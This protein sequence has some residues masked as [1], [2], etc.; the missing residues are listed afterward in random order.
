[1]GVRDV[2]IRNDKDEQLAKYS[3]RIADIVRLTASK[4]DESGEFPFEHFELLEKEGYFKLTIPKEY[5]G[6]EL[7]LYEILL[8]QERLAK[9]SGSTALAVGW[10][11]MTFFN[12]RYSR[13]WKEEIFGRLCTDAVKRGLLLNVFSTEREAGNIVRGG[14]LSTIATKTKEGYVI[15]GR[16]SFATLSP[17]LKHFTVLAYVED[18]GKIAEFLIEKND[19]VEIIESWNALGMRSTGSH[20]VQLNS[21]FVEKEALLS[22]SERL[23]S[24]RFTENSSAYALQ[25]PAIY[26]G[27]ASEAK[28]FIINYA[29]NKYSPSL[30]NTIVN[31]PHVKQKIGE[32]EIHLSVSRSLLYS[33]AEKWDENI[34]LR[35]ELSKEVAIAKYTVCNAAVKIVDLAMD[36]AGGN[37]LSKDL[38]LERYFRDVRCGLYNPP[39]NDMVISQ[40]A[41]SVIDQYRSNQKVLIKI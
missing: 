2:F 18:E 3:N 20:D 6:D 19:S 29:V 30:G 25:I 8:V 36:I 11:L 21:V 27:I 22:Y 34:G 38:P 28:D 12:L 15:T 24:N 40:I 10:N 35:S 14:K 13:P 37:A 31:A 1:M 26:L 23:P 39:H 9:G 32:M 4:Y 5:G 41:S 17:I 7:S 33:L 16:K